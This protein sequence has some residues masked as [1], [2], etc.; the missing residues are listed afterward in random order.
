MSRSDRNPQYYCPLNDKF[1]SLNEADLLVVSR[2]AKE[3][4]PP[5]GEP[6]A[7]SNIVLRRAY[8]AEAE[9]V[10]DMCRYFWDETEIFCFDQTFDLNECVNFLALAEG[11]IAG[12]IS[13][14]R[15]GEAQIVVVLNVYPEFQGQGLG[16]ML[17]KEV[18]EQGRKQ[19]CRV[20]R[21][22]TSNDDLPALCLYQRM[23]FQLTAVVPD[24]L[25]QHHDEEITGFAGIPVRDELRLERRL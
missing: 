21:V 20:I 23:G 9:E 19:G 18:M 4:L 22:A 2:E 8:E 13:W 17:L 10:E 5:P 16:R 14:K 24:V 25:R 12:L 7:K 11:E 1:I 6:V 15:L 3:D